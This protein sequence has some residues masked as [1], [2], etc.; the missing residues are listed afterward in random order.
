[1]ATENVRMSMA[2]QNQVTIRVRNKQFEVGVPIDVDY[3]GVHIRI[4]EDKDFKVCEGV[5][6]LLKDAVI[7]KPKKQQRSQG[8]NATIEWD[9]INRYEVEV[10]EWHRN[11][12]K[13]KVEEE[14]EAGVMTEATA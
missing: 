5:Y 2:G 8:L 11:K 7:E 6:L 1:M 12:G 4:P 14:V 9:K 10:V 13:K 3:N